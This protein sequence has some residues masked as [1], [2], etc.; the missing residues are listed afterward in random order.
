MIELNTIY[1]SDFQIVTLTAVSATILVTNKGW[2]F[3]TKS[4]NVPKT[5]SLEGQTLD[6]AKLKYSLVQGFKQ[7]DKKKANSKWQ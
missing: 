5:H 3:K 4:F 2:I 7:F 1:I 6:L